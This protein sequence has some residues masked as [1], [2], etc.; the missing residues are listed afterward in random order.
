MKS[1][2]VTHGCVQKNKPIKPV[3]CDDVRIIVVFLM[4]KYFKG[5]ISL[6]ASLFL[7]PVAGI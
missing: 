1:H 5:R 2:Q 4:H 7:T 3:K 6:W